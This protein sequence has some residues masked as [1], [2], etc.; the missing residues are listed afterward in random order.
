MT[1][2]ELRMSTEKV[3]SALFS[4]WTQLRSIVAHHEASLNKRWL[5]K[6][7]DQRKKILLSAWPEMPEKH[8]LHF[9]MLRRKSLWKLKLGR[10]F[11]AA[12]DRAAR[13]SNINLED[14][15]Q[16]DRLLRMISSR[17]REHP[18]KF[19]NADR[20]SIQL[21]LRMKILRPEYVAG[22][23]ID[24]Y[25]DE[26]NYGHIIDRC[27]DPED[28]FKFPIGL[29]PDA[30]DGLMIT[31]IQR[32]I[33]QFLVRCS[34]V[35]LHD[36]CLDRLEA[37]D[38][39]PSCSQTL[40]L[41]NKGATEITSL[42]TYTLEAPYNVPDTYAFERLRSFVEARFCEAQDHLLLLKE[43]PGY[44]AE[45]MLERISGATES[46]IIR[47]HHLKK[48][49]SQTGYDLAI[50]VMLVHAYDDLFFWD[51]ILRTVRE[52]EIL[53]VKH[54]T[55]LRPGCIVP[56][57]Y[58]IAF[59]RLHFLTE[60]IGGFYALYTLEA[61][62]SAPSF[63][64][65]FQSAA[66]DGDIFEAIVSGR[67]KLKR[68]L[69][70]DDHLWWLLNT[71]VD[72][73]L[74]DEPFCGLPDLLEEVEYLITKNPTQNARL[75]GR[76]TKLISNMSVVA[77]IHRQLNT[78][79]HPGKCFH[80]L[81]MAEM[82]EKT[83]EKW[84]SRQE[85]R[86]ATDSNNSD[87]GLAR[88]VMNLGIYEYPSDK[89]RTAATTAKMRSAEAALDYFWEEVDSAILSRTGKSLKDFEGQLLPR[90][91][92]ERT[93][94]WEEPASS[95][96]TKA[97]IQPTTDFDTISALALLEE[98]S[99]STIDRSQ[100]TPARI[101]V[102]S[103]G[104][105]AHISETTETIETSIL[106][107][108]EDEDLPKM[109]MLPKI[110]V[111]KK[112]LSTFSALFGKPIDNS[113]PSGGI[114]WIDFR[115]A[116]VNIGFSAEKLQGSAWLFKKPEESRSIIFHEPHP[117]SKLSV[118][119][120]RRIARRLQRRFGWTAESFELASMES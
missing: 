103:R 9:D 15:L 77:E 113:I 22:Y 74:G 47:R 14:L 11:E 105:A 70:T 94:V 84:K 12:E 7:A 32:D 76:L 34:A 44:F 92:M 58:L 114:P 16:S 104:I 26:T 24:L 110:P 89:K 100:S 28:F 56:K 45:Q 20:N 50:A 80:G 81:S 59:A 111:R 91:D 99:E 119:L 117:E 93:S 96:A 102:K 116:M 101:K 67:V 36:L 38:P 29:K 90:R 112:A 78:S 107:T 49:L 66:P 19:T 69:Q 60:S 40:L 13:F 18:S 97:E 63:G 115:K 88:L 43:D 37:L 21:G 27:E 57:E 30:G 17:C 73:G 79:G 33:L 39:Q 98:R 3:L 31:Q 10:S 62:T 86:H 1:I 54:T 106:H 51:I 65:C 8:R 52:L 87:L 83:D 25:S 68:K 109:S 41:T 5:K 35:L 4:A 42:G 71:I 6:T 75:T 108:K 55:E 82:L 72:Y 118:K 85:L 61:L 120:A 64:H 23:N 48:N 95:K 46:V 53:S 2:E